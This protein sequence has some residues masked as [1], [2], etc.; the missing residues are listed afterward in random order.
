VHTKNK[1][2]L[3]DR[4]PYKTKDGYI[5]V[6]ASSDRMFFDFCD[7][8]GR[9]E[10][11]DD[12]RFSERSARAANLKEVYRITEEELAHRTSA[13]W[14]EMLEKADIPASPM[15]TIDTLLKDPHLADVDVFQIEPHPTEGPVRTMKLPM[16]FSATP[17]VNHRP[18]PHVGEQSIDVLR[19]AGLSMQ[20]IEKLIADGV[21]RAHEPD[22]KS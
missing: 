16:H 15:H 11:K 2:R 14:L 1:I 13:E 18:T 10:L 3:L 22:S 20:E 7:L 5:C 8:V 9:P 17:A 12:P 4:R 19:E 6:M 21:V